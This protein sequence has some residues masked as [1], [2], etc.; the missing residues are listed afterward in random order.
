VMEI[1]TD[2]ELQNLLP[3]PAANEVKP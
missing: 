2:A 1:I 3:K